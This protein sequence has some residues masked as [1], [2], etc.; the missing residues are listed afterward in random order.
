MSN[1]FLPRI[2]FG[3]ARFTFMRLRGDIASVLCLCLCVARSSA[4]P[5][6]GV[7]TVY[8]NALKTHPLRTNVATSG[9]ITVAGDTMAQL[10]ARK[11]DQN[12]ASTCQGTMTLQR[13]METAG[14]DVQVVTTTY[15]ARP[16]LLLNVL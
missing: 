6:R 14:L 9:V 16:V 10:V 1:I 7:W 4:H 3:R 15:S 12:Q 11:R 13:W 5:M 8:S 2:F